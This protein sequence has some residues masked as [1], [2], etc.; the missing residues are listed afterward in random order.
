[1]THLTTRLCGVYTVTIFHIRMGS[2]FDSF[3]E[4]IFC[5]NNY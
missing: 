2:C 3:N 1:M 5:F 4:V